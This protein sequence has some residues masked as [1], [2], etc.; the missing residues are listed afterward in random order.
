MPHSFNL[1]DANFTLRTKSCKEFVGIQRP[2]AV[3]I[4]STNQIEQMAVLWQG[5][6]V[7]TMPRPQLAGVQS[8]IVVVVIVTKHDVGNYSLSC[9]CEK[10]TYLTTISWNLRMQYDEGIKV[11]R[12]VNGA[13][14][15]HWRPEVRA[16]G[17][18]A[19]CCEGA[20]TLKMI[21]VKKKILKLVTHFQFKNKA[22]QMS[23]YISEYSNSFSNITS[24]RHLKLHSRNSYVYSLNVAI[25]AEL[26]A[27]IHCTKKLITCLILVSKQ[28]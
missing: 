18:S 26:S 7:I 14:W 1:W 13:S 28:L 22:Y 6:H 23:H 21:V 9:E 16:E 19:G 8:A 2:I 15:K 27:I 3:E 10:H 12:L 20:E 25:S 11:D 5:I 17:P 4:F 24:M